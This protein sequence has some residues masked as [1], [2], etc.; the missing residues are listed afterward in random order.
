MKRI[1]IIA[2]VVET[3]VLIP[4][5]FVAFSRTDTNPVL[6]Y[7][8]AAG[9]FVVVDVTTTFLIRGLTRSTK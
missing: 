2:K 8:L 4:G 7:L 3:A 9:W 1:T 5:V 6:G